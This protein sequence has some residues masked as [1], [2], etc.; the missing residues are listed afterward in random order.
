MAM[1]FGDFTAQTYTRTDAEFG[2][3]SA[4]AKQQITTTHSRLTEV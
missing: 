2:I 3:T 1:S 4:A